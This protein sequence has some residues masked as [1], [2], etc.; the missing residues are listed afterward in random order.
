MFMTEAALP[1][2]AASALIPFSYFSCHIAFSANTPLKNPA[3][4]FRRTAYEPPKKYFLIL[5]LNY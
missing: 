5:A 2:D 1:R 4:Y 3:E